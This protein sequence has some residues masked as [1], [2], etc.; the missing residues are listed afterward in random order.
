MNSLGTVPSEF[1]APFFFSFPPGH[2]SSARLLP[3]GRK[4]VGV[5]SGESRSF[6]GGKSEFATGKVRLRDNS[7]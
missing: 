2:S 5:S 3:E 1:M 6:L 7:R 4:K